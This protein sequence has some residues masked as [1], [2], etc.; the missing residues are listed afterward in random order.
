MKKRFQSLRSNAT[1]CTAT[2]RRLLGDLATGA[3][4]A[5][6]TM[7]VFGAEQLDQKTGNPW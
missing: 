1:S 7:R 4:F 5:G 6:A 3:Q 2:A